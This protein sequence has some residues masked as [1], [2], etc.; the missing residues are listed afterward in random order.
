MRRRR[1]FGGAGPSLWG[2]CGVTVSRPRVAREAMTSSDCRTSARW[3][4]G[5]VRFEKTRQTRNIDAGFGRASAGWGDAPFAHRWV[6]DES[7]E[8][9][10]T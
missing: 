9:T 10:G 5:G 8:S 1:R 7:G 6:I 2:S 3:I 4:E